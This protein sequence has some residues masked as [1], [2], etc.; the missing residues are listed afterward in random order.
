LP[1]A[2]PVQ[3]AEKSS[4]DELGQLDVGWI[5]T[6]IA[7]ILIKNG[8]NV[9]EG[10]QGSR[11]ARDAVLSGRDPE[12]SDPLSSGNGSSLAVCWVRDW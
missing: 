8:R 6:S 11:S 10:P 9:C 4:V 7:N 3:V 2:L 1:V 5:E 12:R